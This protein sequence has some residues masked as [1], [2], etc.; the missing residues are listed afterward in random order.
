MSKSKFEQVAC[1]AV[2]TDFFS[3]Y[4]AACEYFACRFER[5]KSVR[6]P[7]GTWGRVDLYL[8]IFDP[9][10]KKSPRYRFSFEMKTSTTDLASGYGLNFEAENNFIVYPRNHLEYTCSG[11]SLDR[12]YLES[13]LH[14]IGCDY[15]GILCVEDDKSITVERKAAGHVPFY[16]ESVAG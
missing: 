1:E 8:E 9:D 2:A 14:S 10:D 15:V 3:R 4:A 16:A 13:F 11:A 6:K 12:E 5:E 7:A